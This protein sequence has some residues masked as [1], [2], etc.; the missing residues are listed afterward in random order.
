VAI[1]AGLTVFVQGSRVKKIEGI[2]VQ[3]F[4]VLE[5]VEDYQER[6][7]KEDK[8]EAK[9]L[10]RHEHHRHHRYGGTHKVVSSEK[11][12]GHQWFTRH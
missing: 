6:K 10:G 4:D 9:K 11:L 12:K 2:P 5:S 1:F 8:K 3:E 7:A